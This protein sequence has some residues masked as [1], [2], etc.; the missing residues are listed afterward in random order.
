VEVVQR[1]DLLAGL[2]QNTLVDCVRY[3]VVDQLRQ[4]ETVLALI[5][6]LEGIG[7]EGQAVADIWVAGEDSIDVARE[8][9]SLVFV[10]GVSDVRGGALYLNPAT[11]TADAGL[12]GVLGGR[13]CAAGSTGYCAWARWAGAHALLCRRRLAQLGDEVYVVVQLYSPRA[14]EF[15]L[16][17]R[18][19]HYI[20]RL[21]LCLLGGL[22]DGRLVEIPFVVDVE[23]AE[24]ILQ[25][26]DLALLEL[27]V[28]SARN[29]C[30]ALWNLG[31]LRG[32]LPLELDD[33][34]GCGGV[35]GIAE[36]RKTDLRMVAEANTAKVTAW[37]SLVLRCAFNVRVLLVL[38]S[39][40]PDDAGGALA[41]M[42]TVGRRGAGTTGYAGAN[43]IRTSTRW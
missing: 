15:D 24:G 8:L 20:V 28:L 25:A 18:L 23:L 17:Q 38:L 33:I 32:S 2:V 13:G 41:K 14:V 39:L 30:Q 29:G 7:G 34:H 9:G 6:H 43:V 40:C 11:S 27:G 35:G 21:V 5:E 10:D 4:Y 31:D 12:R 1:L 22:N 36:S 42:G 3:A 16:L 37:H 26:K 19:A